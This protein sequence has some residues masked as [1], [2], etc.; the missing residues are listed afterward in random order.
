MSGRFTDKVIVITGAAGGIGRATALRFATE[1]AK[2]VLVDLPCAALEDAGAEVEKEGA[3]ALVVPADVTKAAAV[4][5]YAKEA[6][7]RFGGIDFFFNNAGI[8]GVAS[9]LVDY[10]EDV[11]D[12]VIAVN[13]KGVWLGLKYVAPVIR[14][15]GGGAIVNTSSVGGLKGSN[16][17]FAYIASKHAV[18]G[19]TRSAALEFARSGVRV[20][21]ICPG[22]IDTRMMRSLEQ[23]ARPDDPD[24]YKSATIASTPVRRYGTPE[25]VAG[26]VAFLCSPD[27][28]YITGGVYLVDGGVTA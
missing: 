11:F 6:V 5:G 22:A 26:L 13:V 2:V 28:A 10:P 15:R 16:T 27:A 3:G 19:I 4:E 17:R 7:R 20:N 9:S 23:S 14:A 1:G 12:Q 8:E 18:I 25:E 21:A 24:S